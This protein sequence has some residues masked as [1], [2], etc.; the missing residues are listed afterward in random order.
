MKAFAKAFALVLCAGALALPPTAFA[1]DGER[2]WRGDH[3]RDWRD[4]DR[5]RH[6]GHWK[7]HRH[8][9]HEV[10]YIRERAPVYR[11]RVVE[12]Y[13]VLRAYPQP[14][15]VISLPPVIIPF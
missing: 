12:Y 5:G 2:G 7:H 9:D 15:V 4:H 13:P 6:H 10:V 8:G 1:G 14:A 3:R 11:E